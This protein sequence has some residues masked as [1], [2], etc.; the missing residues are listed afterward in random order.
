MML[1][2]KELRGSPH[3]FQLTD[4]SSFRILPNEEKA[5]EDYLVSSYMRN[6]VELK[7]ISISGET[8]PSLSAVKSH[9]KKSIKTKNK[10]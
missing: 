5:I 8:P 10:K 1:T 9:S 4:N 7:L 6:A 3:V 2:V